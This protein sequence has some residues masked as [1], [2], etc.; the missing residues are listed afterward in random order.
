MYQAGSVVIGRFELRQKLGAGGM[1]IVFGAMD[2]KLDE[3]VAL[4]F[5][6]PAMAGDRDSLDLFAR[7]VK[8]ARKVPGKYILRV[9]D[10]WDDG[11]GGVFVTMEWAK[12]G[13]LNGYR[14]QHGLVGLLTWDQVRGLLHPI[15][16][17]LQTVHEAG[18]VHR[19]VKPANILFREDGTPVVADF[20]ISK[21]IK[22]SMSR[23]SQDATISGTPAYMAPEA[24]RG[25]GV[26]PATDLYAMGCMAYELLTGHTPFVGD[27][28]SIMYNQTHADPSFRGIERNALRWV[29]ACLAKDP[30]RRVQT[31]E[32]LIRGLEDPSRLPMYVPTGPSAVATVVP[33]HQP[34]EA[35]H[36]SSPP[37]APADLT[38]R[39]GTLPSA[40]TATPESARSTGGRAASP[41]GPAVSSS[42]VRPRRKPSSNWWVYVPVGLI[43]L[44]VIL[45]VSVASVAQ[46]NRAQRA[47]GSPAASTGQ[48]RT[49][50]TA[51]GPS[52]S[53]T[54]QVQ[55]QLGVRSQTAGSGSGATSQSDDRAGASE[56]TRTPVI[57]ES[58][59]RPEEVK[60]QAKAV[61]PSPPKVQALC[62]KCGKMTAKT[63][64]GR[65]TECGV[66]LGNRTVVCPT[67]KKWTSPGTVCD[68]CGS[69]LR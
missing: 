12:G 16:L 53:G 39:V 13:D 20:G 49:P 25:E 10:I 45:I 2:R 23:I 36:A 26:S 68:Q 50:A 27:P 56:K 7:E 65:C 62:P 66:R 51:A 32:A 18:I 54:G 1:G 60:P 24:I 21:S 58:V 52:G 59:V 17:G 43:A 41:R 14:K 15:L 6:P 38:R 5:L 3:E 44:L 40:Q 46:R 4:K 34:G 33:V 47:I 64:D 57:P 37:A 35:A 8:R 11:E 42:D 31:A 19:D 30:A 29:G 28:M 67:C 63:S 55:D 9:Y 61:K 48:Y 22:A 69:R